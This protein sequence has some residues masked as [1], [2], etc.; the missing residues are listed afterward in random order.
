MLRF[1]SNS[2][3]TPDDYKWNVKDWFSK[4]IASQHTRLQADGAELY[5]IVNKFPYL[6]NKYSD[7]D[8]VTFVGDDVK[9]ITANLPRCTFLDTIKE[10]NKDEQV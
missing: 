9:F 7:L 5:Y 6:R 10:E 1:Y 4:S 3:L 8:V 2:F